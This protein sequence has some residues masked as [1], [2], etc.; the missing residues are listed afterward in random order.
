MDAR[1]AN[2]A[3]RMARRLAPA[4]ALVMATTGCGDPKAASKENF[5]KALTAFFDKN[6]KMLTATRFPQMLPNGPPFP[7]SLGI[8]PFTDGNLPRYQALAAAGLLKRG[9]ETTTAAPFS[10]PTRQVSFDLTDKGKALFQTI[11]AMGPGSPPGFCAGHLRVVSVDSFTQPATLGGQLVSQV[12]ATLKPE[13]DPWTRAPEL[14][15]AFQADLGQTA[16]APLA[17]PL[18][19]RNDGWAVA[20]SLPAAGGS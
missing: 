8:A 4:M 2:P 12:T 15:P 3:R 19:L 13:F 10:A 7:A 9:P 20:T 17:L 1:T 5:Q 16:P 14:Q 11:G 18:V 6:C